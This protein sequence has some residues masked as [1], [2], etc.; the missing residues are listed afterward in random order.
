MSILDI[1]FQKRVNI[2]SQKKRKENYR[3]ISLVNIDTK[4]ST[5]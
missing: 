3:L 2:S 5:K 4:S 1:P